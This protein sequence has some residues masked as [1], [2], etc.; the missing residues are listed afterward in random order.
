MRDEFATKAAAYNASGNYW[1]RVAFLI[2]C[3]LGLLP[4]LSG[5]VALSPQLAQPWL[6]LLL[7]AC[8]VLTVVAQTKL[9]IGE[10]I[11]DAA[12]ATKGYEVVLV[13]IGMFAAEVDCSTAPPKDPS[14]LI[15]KVVSVVANVESAISYP[16]STK[17]KPSLFDC[18]CRR[19]A[20]RR[21]VYPANHTPS[22]SFR[23]GSAH[24]AAR[25]WDFNSGRRLALLLTACNVLTVVAQTKLDIGERTADAAMATKGYEVVLVDISMFIAE[26]DCSTST[27]PPKDPSQLLTKVVSV[28]ANVESAIKYPIIKKRKPS[29]ASRLF[30]CC[31]RRAAAPG[32]VYPLSGNIPEGATI[33]SAV[34]VPTQPHAGGIP[35]P[36][37]DIPGIGDASAAGGTKGVRLG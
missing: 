25:A 9:D 33:L 13:D 11:A 19:A 3:I 4:V 24:E 31:C 16:I 34:P 17:R 6:A 36:S 5:I 27:A 37:E 15:A 7:T 12:M 26:V 2:A 20:A 14:Q 28:V 35:T 1:R 8:N 30:D 22:D 18:C 10:R 29:L 21:A 23:G 32:A